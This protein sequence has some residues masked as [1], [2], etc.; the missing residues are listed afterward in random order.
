MF[1]VMSCFITHQRNP[2]PNNI[3]NRY[4]RLDVFK[5]VLKTYSKVNFEHVYLYVGLD[6]EFLNRKDELEEFVY[7][8]FGKDKALLEFR[9]FLQQN[10]WGPL[11]ETLSSFGEDNLIFFMQNDDHPFIDFNID[12][13]NEGISLLENDKSYYKMLTLSHWPESI[14]AAYVHNNY[15]K[16]NN[17]IHTRFTLC[18]SMNIYNLQFLKDVIINVPWNNPRYDGRIDSVLGGNGQPWAKPHHPLGPHMDNLLSAWVP[19]RE[20]CRHFDG[21]PCQYGYDGAFPIL[22]LP[23]DLSNITPLT[24]TK[25]EL[26]DRFLM[27]ENY[28]QE[29][30]GPFKLPKEWIDTMLELYKPVTIEE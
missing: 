21:Y 5:Y 16:V 3:G 24:F 6:T 17:Y 26:T 19:L 30:H 4:N 14:S 15:E 1:L 22:Q 2:G 20:L 13:L 23:P 9:R 12:L 10:E 27:R 25:Q 18:D 8:I 7:N 29:S 28:F 11:M